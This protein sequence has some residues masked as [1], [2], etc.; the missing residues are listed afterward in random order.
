[1][2]HALPSKMIVYRRYEGYKVTLL[3]GFILITGI[4]Q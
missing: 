2:T 3:L 4:A 1:M